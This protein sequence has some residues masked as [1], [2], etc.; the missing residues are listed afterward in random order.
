MNKTVVAHY[1][2][3][4]FP[5]GATIPFFIHEDGDYRRI[6]EGTFDKKNA[7][8]TTTLD[9]ETEEGKLLLERIYKYNIRDISITTD[10]HLSNNGQNED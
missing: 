4:N 7:L 2:S 8:I 3:S 10:A 5:D 1:G 9:P 6:G